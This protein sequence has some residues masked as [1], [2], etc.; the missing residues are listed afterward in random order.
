M[1][2]TIAPIVDSR[3]TLTHF[4]AIYR[5]ISDR[6]LLERQLVQAEKMQSV[7]TLA[8]G[9]AHEFNNLLAGM[10]G[11]AALALREPGTDGAVQVRFSSGLDLLRQTPRFV[12]DTRV[13]RLE[14]EF[15]HAYRYLEPLFDGKN[16]YL[17]AI[18]RNLTFLDRVLRTERWPLLRRNPPLF[19]S[20]DDQINQVRG[21]MLN[22]L[23]LLWA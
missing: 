1:S 21:L 13:S 10:Q 5:D 12:R 4:V 16:P 3:G 2:L 22:R 17:E 8:G 14:G 18:E 19:T 11:Y 23:K 7:G 20:N 15:E 9:V 6:K